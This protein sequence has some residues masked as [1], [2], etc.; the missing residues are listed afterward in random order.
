MQ[1]EGGTDI[2]CVYSVMTHDN[3]LMDRL[4]LITDGQVD[5]DSVRRVIEAMRAP[6]SI[7]R[8]FKTEAHIITSSPD[9]SVIAPFI[10]DV[11]FS[12]YDKKGQVVAASKMPRTELMDRIASIMTG[13]QLASSFDELHARLAADTIVS[14][15]SIEVREEILAL[16]NRIALESSKSKPDE[17]VDLLTEDGLLKVAT[18]FY[19][20]KAEK[21]VDPVQL[22]TALLKLCDTAGNF[23]ISRL[24][25]QKEMRIFQEVDEADLEA[26]KDEAVESF[27]DNVMMDVDT[28]LSL[29]S[30]A[31]DPILPHGELRQTLIRCPLL[32]LGQTELV[33]KLL[34]RIQPPHGL[35]MLRAMRR[36]A[37]ESGLGP[38]RSPETREP[39]MDEVLVFGSN[40]GETTHVAANKALISKL[41]FG[42]NKMAGPYSLWMLV[43]WHLL[44]KKTF[45]VEAMGQVMDSHMKSL[46]LHTPNRFRVFL[47]LSPL[48]DRPTMR[49]PVVSSLLYGVAST[50]FWSSQELTARDVMRDLFGAFEAMADALELCGLGAEGGRSVRER[51]GQRVLGIAAAAKSLRQTKRAG[52]KAMDWLCSKFVGSIVVPA[53]REKVPGQAG[54]GGRAARAARGGV[55]GR[56]RSG[57]GGRG[58]RGGGR[59]GRGGHVSGK[60]LRPK[61][62]I[63]LDVEEREA[64]EEECIQFT[65]MK[66]RVVNRNQKLSGVP[67]TSMGLPPPT[68]GLPPPTTLNPLKVLNV[69]HNYPSLLNALTEDQVAAVKV[70]AR[71]LRPFLETSGGKK[72]QEA[73]EETWLCK[74]SELPSMHKACVDHFLARGKF[75]ATQ[76][77]QGDLLLKLAV[78]MK[79]KGKACLPAS[80][81]ALLKQTL[82]EVNEAM[83]ERR[84]K[85]GEAAMEPGAIRYDLKRGISREGR[86]VMEEEERM[87]TLRQ[88]QWP[89]PA[90]AQGTK[91][92]RE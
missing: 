34:A 76:A 55:G 72:W 87:G 52:D 32:L 39:L 45:V 12:V 14:E 26:V 24:R 27:I 46:L 8:W 58:G 20:N 65:L 82:V 68:M 83:E 66:E 92:P 86:R 7:Q 41:I 31:A 13:D 75:P 60:I 6:G 36:H 91:R 69:G 23:S 43:L 21:A 40:V 22:V 48:G 59:G 47:G 61:S 79:A 19:R 28:P 1:A 51:Y 17:P 42:T 2:D 38:V 11:P 64:T 88:V 90:E 57:R 53:V 84:V 67:L 10:K 44:K 25:A 77:E 16:K 71:T 85:F 35:G 5:E 49:V 56:G 9:T 18:E 81:H 33:E 30:A 63:L 50:R 80:A 3:L 54:A 70:S 37:S 29:F 74:S 62:L 15:V 4:V 73:A 89:T 78:K